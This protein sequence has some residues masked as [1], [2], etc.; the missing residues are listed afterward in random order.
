MTRGLHLQTA[1]GALNVVNSLNFQEMIQSL[2]IHEPEWKLLT[3]PHLWL[4]KTRP[5]IERLAKQLIFSSLDIMGVPRFAVPAEWVAAVGVSFI[6]ECNY[7]LYA[8]WMGEYA[9]AEDLGNYDGSREAKIEGLEK[10]TSAQIFALMLELRSDSEC[11]LLN[12][13]FND[14]TAI[15]MPNPLEEQPDEEE[16]NKKRGKVS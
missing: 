9:R 4:G 11:H 7:F 15:A 10:C 12:R 13:R 1:Q 16:T 6:K 8:S 2:G 3:G 5:V 14:K